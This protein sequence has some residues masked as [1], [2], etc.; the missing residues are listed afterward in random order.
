MEKIL[1]SACLTG[2]KCKYD[3]GTNVFPFFEQLSKKDELVPF[4]PEVS[5]GLPTPREPAEIVKNS[6]LTKSGKDVT[7]Q[8]NAG[9]EAALKACKFF[10]IRIAILKDNSPSCGPRHIDDGHF[11]HSVWAM[12]LVQTCL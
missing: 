12:S 5:G 10:G 8:Y 3:G 2:E 4:C 9:A 6:V 1:I 7:Q 11:T